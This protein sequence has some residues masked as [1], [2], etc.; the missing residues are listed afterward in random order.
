MF[1][2]DN[3]YLASLS[4]TGRLVIPKAIRQKLCLAEKDA[5]VIVKETPGFLSLRSVK[6]LKADL[7]AEILEMAKARTVKPFFL[8]WGICFLERGFRIFVPKGYREFASIEESRKSSQKGILILVNHFGQIE[9]WSIKRR[10]VLFREYYEKALGIRDKK[11]IAMWERGV[12]RLKSIET[13]RKNEKITIAK[14][15][16]GF[17]DEIV[18]KIYER[19]A[20]LKDRK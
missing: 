10:D 9:I 12:L 4:Y 6:K 16:D 5:M 15:R 2:T 17:E 7:S 3:E 19:N 8:E 11:R 1:G 18:K 14:L 20:R 13:K